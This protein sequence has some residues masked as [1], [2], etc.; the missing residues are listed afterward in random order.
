MILRKRE[1]NVPWVRYMVDE[2]YERRERPTG[3]KTAP[4]AAQGAAAVEKPPETT[5]DVAERPAMPRPPTGED[6]RPEKG[7]RR[8]SNVPDAAF[9]CRE[10]AARGAIAAGLPPA[11]G[12]PPTV[13]H[14]LLYELD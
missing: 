3:E 13:M 9:A 6:A 12:P 14:E 1:P 7:F 10:E 2:S 8:E 5:D 4:T 11:Q